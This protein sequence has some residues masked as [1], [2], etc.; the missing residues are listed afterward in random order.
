[1]KKIRESKSVQETWTRFN[2]NPIAFIEPTNSSQFPYR[3]F[4]FPGEIGRITP[5]TLLILEENTTENWLG[6]SLSVF[7][8]PECPMQTG[9]TIQKNIWKIFKL[10]SSEI[11]V[12][13][14]VEILFYDPDKLRILDF[15]SVSS[16]D[17]YGI[18]RIL[19]QIIV[20]CSVCPVE[21][22]NNHLVGSKYL[23][24]FN[25]E[26]DFTMSLRDELPFSLQIQIQAKKAMVASLAR[27]FNEFYI[28]ENNMGFVMLF[29]RYRMYPQFSQLCSEFLE[30]LLIKQRE[31]SKMAL[32]ASKFFFVD[33]RSSFVSFPFA[34]FNGEMSQWNQ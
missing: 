2:G 14:R 12:S 34:R 18:L 25:E 13:Q 6:I 17:V 33:L 16:D 27:M 26:V 19:T 5:K 22:T 10:F 11:L 8:G 4:M 30:P 23:Y 3:I 21:I 28:R 31:K 7:S 29:E 20:F 24:P 1:M 15:S 32:D 9:Q